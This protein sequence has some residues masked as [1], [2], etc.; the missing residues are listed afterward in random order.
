MQNLRRMHCLP[1]RQTLE[2]TQ[3]IQ[4]P[5]SIAKSL[6]NVK[7]ESVQCTCLVHATKS[8]RELSDLK[9]VDIVDGNELARTDTSR[10]ISQQ[11]NSILVHR[12]ALVS[13]SNWVIIPNKILEGTAE[14]RLEIV[15][16]TVK[17]R[18]A[19]HAQSKCR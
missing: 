17:V 8:N 16:L 15:A 10:P 7:I 9:G 12:D 11:I 1:F 14:G 5:N 19:M 2:E 3:H 4:V 6:A 18:V 13:N